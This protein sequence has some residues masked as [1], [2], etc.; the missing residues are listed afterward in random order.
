MFPEFRAATLTGGGDTPALNATLYG[1]ALAAR[2]KKGELIGFRRGWVGPLFPNKEYLVHGKDSEGRP[3][4]T[5]LEDITGEYVVLKP[6]LINPNQGGSI[7]FS[8][9]TDLTKIPG[10]L[11][12]VATRLKTLNINYFLPIGGEDTNTVTL[13]A[14]RNGIFHPIAVMAVPK[15]IDNDV[16]LV[17]PDNLFIGFEHM[18][19]FFDPGHPSANRNGRTFVNRT[20]STTYTH[21]R[22]FWAEAMGRH[23]GFLTIGTAHLGNASLAIVP[24]DPVNIED[25]AARTLKIYKERGFFYGIVSEGAINA[26]TGK[27]I[28]QDQTLWDT[29]GHGKLGG[30][31]KVIASATEAYFKAHGVRAPYHNAQIPE[32]MFRGGPPT[33]EDKEAA[34]ELGYQA[35][36]ELIENN[37]NGH[38]AVL[39]WNGVRAVPSTMP[40][41][42][43]VA[44]DEENRI[45]PRK[46]PIDRENPEN[47][48][49]DSNTKLPTPL[50]R[51]Y[52]DLFGVPPIRFREWEGQVFR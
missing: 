31:A 43:A 24:E 15:T 48:F 20:R 51:Q 2:D 16:G 13:Y 12:D 10:A 45:K 37:R 27:L 30:A 42:Q 21:E 47:G 50:G 49:Y 22:V 29:F 33:R 46:L 23:A 11:E 28:S 17:G 8:S 18:I 9:R 6:E 39:K 1:M 5:K 34:I 44:T 32:Y 4:I 7:I 14:L 3:K 25:I 38:M 19:N 41:E 35:M 52:V 26:E 40:L 36:T